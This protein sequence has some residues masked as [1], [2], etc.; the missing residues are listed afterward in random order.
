MLIKVLNCKSGHLFKGAC[1]QGIMIFYQFSFIEEGHEIFQTAFH[2]VTLK[3]LKCELG[4]IP[5]C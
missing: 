1:N 2:V 4:N 5:W 3:F